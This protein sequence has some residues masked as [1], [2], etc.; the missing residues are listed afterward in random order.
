MVNL[1]IG[2]NILQKKNLFEGFNTIFFGEVKNHSQHCEIRI[3]QYQIIVICSLQVIAR[4]L[5]S[6]QTPNHAKTEPRLNYLLSLMQ[7]FILTI[8]IQ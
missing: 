2:R 4:N 7:K 5:L 3:G 6:D 1:E 8:T